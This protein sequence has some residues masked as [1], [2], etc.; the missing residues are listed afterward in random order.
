M[1][2][3]RFP[4]KP[5][6]PLFGR[7]M[8]EHVWYRSSLSRRTTDIVVA[9]CDDEIRRVVEGFGGKVV[10]TATTHERGTDRIAEAAAALGLGE[11][12]IAINVQG[13]EPMLVPEM[14]DDAVAPL[15]ADT[16][17][18]T[19]NL[20]APIASDA[21]HEDPNEI[22]VV[23][24]R[25]GDALFMSR[26]PVPSNT[27]HLDGVPRVKQVCVIAFRAP[28]LAR[29]AS[30]EPTPLEKAESIDMMRLIENGVRVR[31]VPTRAETYAVDTIEGLARVEDAIR[32]DARQY[33][34]VTELLARH[35]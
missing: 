22:K 15:L 16:A 7:P 14:I 12:D 21:E 1:G 34:Y 20:Y 24:D 32:R 30:L 13:D 23:I 5:L 29:F 31:M 35:A 19:T 17:L 3:S 27:R 28:L 4:N 18:Q 10:M 26:A 8:I 6:A 25:A 2:S 9:T 11:G 33:R